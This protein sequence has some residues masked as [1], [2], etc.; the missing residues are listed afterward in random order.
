MIALARPR[1]VPSP[2][3]GNCLGLKAAIPVF[4]AVCSAH[5]FENYKITIALAEG[6]P[7]DVDWRVFIQRVIALQAYLQSIIDDV[8]E[9]WKLA[10]DTGP[11]PGNHREILLVE[12]PQL[13]VD[14]PRKESVV[15]KAIV[16]D[17]ARR[18]RL[19]ISGPL[20]HYGD[21]DRC[22]PG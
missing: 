12:N 1:S 6:W 15:W 3:P 2:R 8:D 13:L 17:I 10:P 7:T 11:N 20:V 22:Q 19:H 14:R 18:G 16:N 9:D 4:A 5:E 21:F